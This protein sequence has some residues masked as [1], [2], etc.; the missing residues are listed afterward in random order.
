MKLEVGKFYRTRDSRK[1]GPMVKG[2]GSQ[3]EWLKDPKSCACYF[4]DGTISP[5][6]M[7]S[8]LIA[9][10]Q[11]EPEVEDDGF[12]TFHA[13]RANI[14]DTAKQAVTQD[15]QAT[16]GKPEDTFGALAK[17]WSARLG[18][19]VTPAQVCIMLV[20]LK[21][22]RAWGNPCHADN[23]VDMAGY[24]ACGGELAG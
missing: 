24:A 7:G 11:D 18:Q 8:D 16:H 10:W 20:D 19:E 6:F 12:I 15:R 5:L 4:M 13:T 23:W 22:C 1:A 9:E 14:L 17:V 2:P 3:R 21:T